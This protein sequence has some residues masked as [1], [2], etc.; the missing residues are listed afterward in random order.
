MAVLSGFT[1]C[2]VFVGPLKLGVSEVYDACR[3]LERSRRYV[4]E[5]DPT[6]ERKAHGGERGRVVTGQG[7]NR[8]RRCRAG[9]PGLSYVLL[10]SIPTHALCSYLGI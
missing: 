1:A 6:L 10:L 4:K 7:S 3:R 8:L 2:K 5:G 9:G